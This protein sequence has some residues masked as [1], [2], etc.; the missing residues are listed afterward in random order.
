M[1]Q[2]R[3]HVETALEA[4][5]ELDLPQAAARHAQ[6][7]RAQPGD[8]L[9][10]FDGSGT[11]HECELLAMGRRAV[12]VRVG[13]RIAAPAPESA[14]A[15]TLAFGMPAN[16][17]MDAMV[18]KA[19]ELGA[20][21]L[22]P[23]MFERSVLRL[24]GE[25]AERRRAHWRA[26]AIAACEQ[27]GRG[28]VPEVGAVLDLG[29]WLAA[30]PPA[31]VSARWLLSTAADA[32]PFA[33]VLRAR[34]QASDGAALLILSGPEGGFAPAEEAAARG[35]GFDPVSLGPRTLRADTAPLAA[36]AAWSLVQDPPV[37]GAG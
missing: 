35:A 28:R 19:T 21:C 33:T 31:R 16:E 12:R 13:A 7:R 29:A 6:V 14:S 34:A 27:C 25:R 30:P 18:E 20:A 10:L 1:P 23:L 8:R 15:V 2:L 24:Q 32:T 22:Q 5:A 36:L 26:V 3:L 11:D 9:R 17:R 4:G 37:R